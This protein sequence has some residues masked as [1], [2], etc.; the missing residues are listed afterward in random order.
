MWLH[1]RHWC[2]ALTRGPDTRA[3][4]GP[5]SNT[6]RVLAYYTRVVLGPTSNTE[7]VV[8]Y[9]TR[10]VSGPTSNTER[11]LAYYRRVVSGPTSN[12]ERVLAYNTP[13]VSLSPCAICTNL[14]RI[15]SR[16][17]HITLDPDN[18]SPERVRAY[19]SRCVS[20]GLEKSYLVLHTYRK[21]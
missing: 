1:S 3:V 9:Y 6:E 8:A 5:T 11:V 16:S 4:S 2:S 15:W 14:F 21:K 20:G 17:R 13:D 12:T 18:S 7:R 10:V 19:Y